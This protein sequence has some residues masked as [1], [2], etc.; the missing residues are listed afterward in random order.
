MKFETLQ[1]QFNETLDRLCKASEDFPWENKDAYISW[2]GQSFEYVN[3]VTRIL[4]LTGGRF[5]LGQT[6]HSNRFIQHAAEEKGHDRLLINDAKAFGLDVRA[7]PVLP[8][9]EAFHKSLYY[10]IYQGEP[11]VILG[12]ALFLESFAVKG[13]PRMAERV[14]A[15]HGKRAASFIAVHTHEDVDHVEKGF[16]TMRQLSESELDGVAHGLELYSS[17]YTE[18]YTA[19]AAQFGAGSA[20]GKKAA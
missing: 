3:S 17:L 1:K 5:P 8:V 2:I 13:G 4:A 11:I 12:W 18:I 20:R 15:A 10:W 7:I 6:A 19:I 9:A 14:F 16:E